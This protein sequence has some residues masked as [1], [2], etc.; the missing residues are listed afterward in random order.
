MKRQIS[1]FP[2]LFSLKLFC[3]KNNSEINAPLYK[4]IILEY[5]SISG[6]THFEISISVFIDKTAIKRMDGKEFKINFSEDENK[7]KDIL[8]SEFSSYKRTYEPI[9]SIW[10]DINTYELINK[11]SL[12]PDTVSIYEPLDT[13]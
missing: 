12:V 2:I 10:M 4:N 11:N 7:Q 3:C 1:I 8:I 13:E 9:N 5:K 6:W